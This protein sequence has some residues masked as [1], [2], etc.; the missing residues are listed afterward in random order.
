M[1]VASAIPMRLALAAAIVATIG[2][3][4]PLA[5]G[6]GS[7][8]R[9]APT[10]RH[11]TT[12]TPVVQSLPVTLAPPVG[13]DVHLI[14][15]VASDID[16]DGDLDLIAN[17]G[18]LDLLVWINDGAGHFI[19]HD[20]RPSNN[21]RDAPVTVDDGDETSTASAIGGPTAS[22]ASG[23]AASVSPTETG[24]LRADD[25]WTAPDSMLAGSHGPRAPPAAQSLI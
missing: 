3:A 12:W 11:R 5:D 17:D 1:F 9:P 16:A 18:S 25:N 22:V 7:N 14:A 13:P 21:W 10:V 6:C 24:G 2:A 23:D 4:W 19:R 15:L 20:A 8:A